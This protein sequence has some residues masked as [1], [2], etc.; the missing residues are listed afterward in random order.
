MI[1]NAEDASNKR[2]ILKNWRIVPYNKKGYF[3]HGYIYNNPI[4]KNGKSIDT[5]SVVDIVTCEN[6][7]ITHTLHSVYFLPKESY[8]GDN[9]YRKFLTVFMPFGEKFLPVLKNFLQRV[10]VFTVN[11]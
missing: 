11:I 1:I 10:I 5:T 8:A 7:Y 4:F 2:F 9:R 3:L 6:G